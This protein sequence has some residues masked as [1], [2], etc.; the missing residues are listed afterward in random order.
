M[1]GVTESGGSNQKKQPSPEQDW[2]W[3]GTDFV[4]SPTQEPFVGRFVSFFSVFMHGI[5]GDAYET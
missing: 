2:K 1:S 4:R 5:L 3:S